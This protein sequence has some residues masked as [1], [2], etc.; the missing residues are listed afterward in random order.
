[1][2]GP[3][4]PVHLLDAYFYPGDLLLAVLGRPES[5]GAL[6]PGL[7]EELTA[8]VAGLSE[9]ETAELTAYGPTGWWS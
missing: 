5:A 9:K 1:M 8:V 6:L 3:P 7:R 2:N 4:G